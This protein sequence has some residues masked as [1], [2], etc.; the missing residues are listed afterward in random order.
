MTFYFSFFSSIIFL[1]I[2][3][4][5][6]IKTHYTFK[7]RDSNDI[8]LSM[9]EIFYL[10]IW[11]YFF[12]FLICILASIL[13][14]NFQL[15]FSDANSARYMISALIQ[16]EAAILAIVITLSLVVVQQTA[17]SFSPRVIEIFKDFKKNPDFYL[18][19]AIYLSV[20]IYSALVLKII[21]EKLSFT[22][23]NYDF[24]E[25]SLT[26]GND[27]LSLRIVETSQSFSI[28]THIWITYFLSIF[29]FI[30]LIGYIKHTMD[31]LNPSSLIRILS[32][33][34][35]EERLIISSGYKVIE[36]CK[37]R[38]LTSIKYAKELSNYWFKGNTKFDKDD[39][40]ILPLIDIIRGS[41]MRYDYETSMNALKTIEYKIIT[42]IE[43]D[44]FHTRNYCQYVPEGVDYSRYSENATN[45]EEY[46]HY[47]IKKTYR[48][49]FSHF[50]RLGQLAINRIDYHSSME[51]IKVINNLLEKILQKDEIN[52]QAEKVITL[53]LPQI[54]DNCSN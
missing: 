53:T 21:N 45:F 23:V 10:K 43:N 51:I 39:D 18:L 7:N 2:V 47:L 48:N 40:P 34:I 29:A 6:M 20:I 13:T 15:M 12:L 36:P 31:L 30:A 50:E 35:T 37:Y 22:K 16:S 8:K 33:D 9:N 26:I 25:P 52:P 1:A 4:V 54:G 17:S 3:V 44:D 49:I 28:Q 42:L 19:I 27:F 5:L 32:D 46:K 38:F 11:R 41:L 14:S 24:L